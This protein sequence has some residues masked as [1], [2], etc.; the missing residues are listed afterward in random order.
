MRPDAERYRKYP[1]EVPVSE[2]DD[3]AELLADLLELRAQ[4][5]AIKLSYLALKARYDPNQPR[6]PRGN[7]DGGQW[8]LVA[9]PGGRG[10]GRYGG[11][12][13][14][15]SP[16][17]LM[18][19]DL[20]IA[21]TQDV[22]TQVRQYDP[23]WR[24]QAEIRAEPG[25]IE[26]AIRNAEG[27]TAEAQTQLDKLRSGI[28]GNFG[29]PIGQVLPR[30]E[31]GPVQSRA[32]DG[33][34]WIH[35]YRIANN[36]PDLFG[37]PTWPNDRGTVAATQMDGKFI[38]GVN[39]SAPGYTAED[40]LDADAMREKLIGKYPDIMETKNIGEFPNNAAYHAESVALY[41]ASRANG[42]TLAGKFL[43]MHVDRELCQSCQTILPNVALELGN[44]TVVFVNTRTGARNVVRN[45][46]LE[47]GAR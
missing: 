35:A 7:P 12:F 26:S 36:M 22:V 47:R 13:P 28:G 31:L 9:G 40:R 44:P 21:R 37:Q 23:N 43:E 18:R 11:Y 30:A 41:R 4:L 46:N 2:P 3:G 24:P 33:P 17:Q 15:A 38:F 42:G 5:R 14:G 29:P 27:R 16:G 34:A 1:K 45:G 25:N 20:A 6:V 39:S 8:T 10:T 32:F 19:L